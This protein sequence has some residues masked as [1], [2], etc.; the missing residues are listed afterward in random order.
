MTAEGHIC[1]RILWLDL[2]SVSHLT[3]PHTYNEFAQSYQFI[4]DKTITIGLF[5]SPA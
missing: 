2:E 5:L 1:H 4:F 3:A